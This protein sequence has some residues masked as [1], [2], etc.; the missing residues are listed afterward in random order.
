MSASCTKRL[1]IATASGSLRLSVILLLLRC[2]FWKSKPWRL[3]P[4]PSPSRPPGISILIASAPQSTSCRTQVG[5]ARARVRSR[6]LKRASGYEPLDAI[7][8][9]L[10]DVRE[11]L[12]KGYGS[13]LCH[14]RVDHARG[15][16]Q[17]DRLSA[18][19]RQPPFA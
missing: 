17:A 4:M 3:P 15:Y 18:A 9:F 10:Y 5:P 6:T 16:A 2:R 14:N 11:L 13:V 8:S 1:K 7:A 12:S 19:I